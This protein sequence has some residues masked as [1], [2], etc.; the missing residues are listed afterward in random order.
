MILSLIGTTAAFTIYIENM[1]RQIVGR[2]IHDAIVL[3]YLTDEQ[4]MLLRRCM[5]DVM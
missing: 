5:R 2:V 1:Q 4:E 3:T